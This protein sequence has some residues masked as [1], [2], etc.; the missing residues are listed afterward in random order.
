LTSLKEDFF[1]ARIEET[2]DE[3]S[4]LVT[5][6]SIRIE[7]RLDLSRSKAIATLEIDNDHTEGIQSHEYR[8][9]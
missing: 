7:I 4:I 1:L 3:S 2:S 9:L 8:L 6:P 5:A